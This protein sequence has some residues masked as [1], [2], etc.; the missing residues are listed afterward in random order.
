MAAASLS[1][2]SRPVLYEPLARE[3]LFDL[4]DQ[5]NGSPVVWIR[6]PPGAG[7]TTLVASW[8]QAREPPAVWYQ[9][10]AGDQDP[11]TFFYYLGLAGRSW[12]R[13]QR[14]LPLLTP[15]LSRD[16]VA[17]AHRYFGALFGRLGAH[18]VVVLDNLHELPE[19]SVL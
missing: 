5:C 16:T 7:K 9:V 19:A 12:Q 3:R 2:I 1:K 13:K 14:P 11:A 17:F 8:L 18:G 6:G 10:D 4:L 15:E